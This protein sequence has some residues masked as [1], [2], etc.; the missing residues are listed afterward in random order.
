MHDY[1][2]R[3]KA[4][5]R[6]LDNIIP[7]GDETVRDVDPEAILFSLAK[8]FRPAALLDYYNLALRE[9]TS[10]SHLKWNDIDAFLREHV[11]TTAVTHGKVAAIRELRNS[12]ARR[13][14]SVPLKTAQELIEDNCAGELARYEKNKGR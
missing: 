5:L 13:N 2:T 14:M 3:K 9:E 8:H 12:Y 4:L 10:L 6:A 11:C 1:K 7:D